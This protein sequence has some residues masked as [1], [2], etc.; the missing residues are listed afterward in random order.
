MRRI[1]IA[2]PSRGKS[3]LAD[4]LR[5][6]S[7]GTLPVYCGDTASKVLYQK[8]YTIYLPEWLPFAGDGGAADWIADHWFTKP[9]P[10]ICEGHALAR[11]L[12]RWMEAAPRGVMPCDKIIVLDHEAHRATTPAQE[13]MH[14]GVMTQWRKV[15]HYYAAIT[16]VRRQLPPR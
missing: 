12:K 2:G 3:T 14:K 10:W 1:I 4:K 13:A 5:K 6:E 16:E 9:G 8:P 15:A 7:G 11:A